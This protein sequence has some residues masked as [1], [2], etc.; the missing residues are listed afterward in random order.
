[1]PDKIDVQKL[2][3]EAQAV[4]ADPSVAKLPMDPQTMIRHLR[5]TAAVLRNVD[6]EEVDQSAANLEYLADTLEQFHRGEDV[7]PLE[8]P[9]PRD[10]D[11]K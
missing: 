1:M 4:L 3:E 7:G 2:F 9:F 6:K 11:E 8:L 5:N 10:P